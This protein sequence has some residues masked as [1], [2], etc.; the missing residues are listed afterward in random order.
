MK[1]LFSIVKNLHDK[2]RKMFIYKKS[3]E[4]K[5]FIRKCIVHMICLQLS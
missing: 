4:L 1:E 2:H 5:D 3:D